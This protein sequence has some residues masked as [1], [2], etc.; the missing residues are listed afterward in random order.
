MEIKG[1][2][3]SFAQGEIDWGA[4]KESGE[5]GFA[6][7]RS[8]YGWNDDASKQ[9][10]RC[11]YK[12]VEGCE[13]YGIPYGIY[14]Y[15]YSMRLSGAEREAEYMLNAIKG[16]KPE[17]PIWFDIEDSAQISLGRELLTQIAETFCG[18][19]SRE[20]YYVGIYSYKE[21]LRNYL[22]MSRLPY[23]VWLAQWASS[24]TYQGDYA[25][26]QY[27]CTGRIAGINGNVDLDISYKDYPA[28]IKEGGFNGWRPQSDARAL[29]EKAIVLQ[30]EALDTLKSLR[31]LI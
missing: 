10:D 6:I 28:I 31:E 9:I 15:S 11:F 16:L 22:D 1:I 18:R 7:I 23:D 8:S 26:W 27:S 17:Y 13:R 20:G 24:P 4:V 12:N 2:D 5:A 14:H 3:V 19:M 29:L 21:F 25:M 30:S